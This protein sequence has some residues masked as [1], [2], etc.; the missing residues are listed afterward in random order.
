MD[1]LLVASIDVALVLIVTAQVLARRRRA[2]GHRSPGPRRVPPT[3][4]L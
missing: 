4:G 2:A 3:R 1:I